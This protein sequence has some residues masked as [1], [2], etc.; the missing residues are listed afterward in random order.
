MKKSGIYILVIVAFFFILSCKK[1][2][3]IGYNLLSDDEIVDF[4]VIDTISINVHTYKIDSIK[5]NQVNNLLLGI[6]DDLY[7]G[8]AE[9]SCAMQF[10]N[11]RSVEFSPKSIAD[12][13]Y[14]FLPYDTIAENNLNIYGNRL[15]AQQLYVYELSKKLVDSI[16][17]YSNLSPD[18]L[19]NNVELGSINYTPYMTGS[20]ELK[21]KLNKSLAE[22]FVNADDSVYNDFTDFLDI[23]K[24]LCLTTTT[25]GVITK[26]QTGREAKLVLYSH[27]T[28]DT[29]TIKTDTFRISTARINMFK[30][31]HSSM[32]FYSSLNDAD[33]PQDSVAYLQSM[34]GL[35]VKITFP[36]ISELKNLGRIAILRAELIVKTAPGIE[37]QEFTYPALEKVHVYRAVDDNIIYP[38]TEYFIPGVYPNPSIVVGIK[39]NKEEKQYRI[40]LADYLKKI[41]NEEIENNGLF[42]IPSSGKNNFNRSIITTGNHSNRMRLVLSFRYLD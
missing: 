7:F 33:M 10:I 9:A 23:F 11:D 22:R 5:S 20:E 14:L 38:L 39:Y 36:F 4:D 12:S 26:F 31:D 27:F 42:L 32:P 3:D 21:I 30:Q 18:F 1:S 40:E 24:G 2:K 37:T 25:P 41:I 17:G 19:H 34:G 28:D 35:K 6:Y 8:R 13:I 15:L 29:D 16:H